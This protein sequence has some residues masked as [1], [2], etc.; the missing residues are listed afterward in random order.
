MSC[1]RFD[2]LLQ[3]SA[4]RALDEAE[5]AEFEGHMAECAACVAHM[6]GYVLTTQL[7]QGLN[8]YEEAEPAPPLPAGLAERIL[9]ARASA[10]QGREKTA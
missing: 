10:A 4:L 7:L 3:A 5:Q 2:D 9:A 6:Q 8:A 1:I